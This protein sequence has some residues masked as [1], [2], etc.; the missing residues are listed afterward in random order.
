MSLYHL[1]CKKLKVIKI[2][3]NTKKYINYKKMYVNV[4]DENIEVIQKI[5]ITNLKIIR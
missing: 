2:K 5:K 1:F 3:Q 4:S